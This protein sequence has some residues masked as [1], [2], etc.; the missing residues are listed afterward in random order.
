MKIKIEVRMTKNEIHKFCDKYKIKNY[1]INKD[2]TVDVDGDV[3]LSY[4]NTPIDYDNLVFYTPINFNEVIGDFICYNSKFISF[5]GCPKKVEGNFV[6]SQNHVRSFKYFPMEIK[7]DIDLFRNPISEIWNLFKDRNYID[8]FN[9]LD[10]I[11]EPK[12]ENAKRTI[13]LERLN[14]FL[15][16]LNEKEITKDYI[17]NFNII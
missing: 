6:F 10:I 13:I 3:N 2:M 1:T 14:Y 12:E 9:E 11:N 8:Y 7:G 15:L 17:T 4:Y 5:K 16:D